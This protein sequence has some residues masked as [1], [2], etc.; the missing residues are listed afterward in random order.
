MGH[1]RPNLA[2]R[3]GERAA[4]LDQGVLAAPFKAV[5]LAVEG[6]EV[7]VPIGHAGA[8]AGLVAALPPA[9]PARAAR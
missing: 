1:S 4:Y 9:V 2:L 7:A 5:A 8:Q 3:R 6:D